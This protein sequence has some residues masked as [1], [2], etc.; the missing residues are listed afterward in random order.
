MPATM[1]NPASPGELLREFMG[2]HSATE[3]APGSLFILEFDIEGTNPGTQY[4]FNSQWIAWALPAC[5]TIM[6]GVIAKASTILPVDFNISAGIVIDGKEPLSTTVEECARERRV[7]AIRHL[8]LYRVQNPLRPF[9]PFA[10]KVRLT[11]TYRFSDVAANASQVNH[12]KGSFALFPLSAGARVVLQIDAIDFA[13]FYLSKDGSRA[14]IMSHQ[15]S[16]IFRY[17]V[18]SRHPYVCLAMCPYRQIE[19]I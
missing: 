1:H 14:S 12:R 17:S 7:Y 6:A 3:L 9:V 5:P 10:I 4:P 18:M 13:Y 19:P 16:L 11:V 15:H 2:D 8:S